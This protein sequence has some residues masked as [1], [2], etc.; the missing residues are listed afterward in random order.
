MSSKKWDDVEVAE[1]KIMKKTMTIPEIA[2]R[3]G[4]RV[5]QVTYALYS[6]CKKGKI[7]SMAE[8]RK[9]FDDQRE[10]PEQPK[11]KTFWGWLFG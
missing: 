8:V 11:K 5:P 4:L 3:K 6:Y 1:I 9:R 10:A 7:K 2:E